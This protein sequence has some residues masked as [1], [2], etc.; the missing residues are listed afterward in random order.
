MGDTGANSITVHYEA[1]PH[2]HRS[3]SRIRELGCA[4]GLAVNISTPP[5]F[6]PYLNDRLD[7]LLIMT[8]NPGFG[9]QAL[10]P[11]ALPKIEMARSMFE[12]GRLSTHVQVDGGVK[13]SNIRT[14]ADAGADTSVMGRNFFSAADYVERGARFRAQLS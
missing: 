3:L 10:I 4:V 11:A 1:I 9:G 13:L 14:I 5:D 7:M 8:I 6:L 12:A 2:V